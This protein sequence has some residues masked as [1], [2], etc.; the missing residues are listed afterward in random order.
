MLAATES[1]KQHNRRKKEIRGAEVSQKH[2]RGNRGNRRAHPEGLPETGQRFGVKR[3]ADPSR[4]TGD[5]MESHRSQNRSDKKQRQR[6]FGPCLAE[7][8]GD[9]EGHQSRDE[10]RQIIYRTDA[11]GIGDRPDGKRNGKTAPAGG[12]KG[13]AEKDRHQGL[14]VR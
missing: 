2:P 6:F 12:E 1:G 8:E 11:K 4:S 5:E 7:E 9:D 13:T 10:N 14:E 3:I